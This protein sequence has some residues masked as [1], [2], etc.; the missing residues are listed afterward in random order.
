MDDAT[1]YT[2]IH[3]LADRFEADLLMQALQREGI[4]AIL[5]SFEETAYDGLFVPQRGWGKIMVPESRAAAARLAIAAILEDLRSPRLYEDPQEVDPNLWRQLEAMEPERICS[6]AQ[7]AFN[8]DA[9][10][11]EVP[12]LSGTL[13]CYP[14]LRR[15]EALRPLPS[16]KLDFQLHLVLLHYLLEAKPGGLSGKWVSE[17]D[18]PGG[19]L[20]FRG[21]HAF[22]TARLLEAFGEDPA[23]FKRKC[24]RLGGHP[25]QA[26]DMSFRMWPF[27]KVPLLF[28]LWLGDDEFDPALH[29]RFDATVHHHLQAL[30]TILAMINVVCRN[31]LAA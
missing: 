12:F 19:H 20:F 27:P 16:S 24:E 6:N 11:Y 21:C 1:Q 18:L 14:A 29:I 15:V 17:K 31:M 3:T 5:R 4:P 26:G 8:R 10:A 30:D 7:V 28:V 2:T 23:L 13:R 9:G 22:P 25:A